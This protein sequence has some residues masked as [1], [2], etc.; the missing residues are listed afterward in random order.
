MR[1]LVVKSII[2]GEFPPYNYLY[3]YFSVLGKTYESP[4]KIKIKV[5]TVGVR[6]KK[7]IIFDLF[8]ESIN[9]QN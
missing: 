5:L 3:F 9:G 1:T 6:I 4:A 7:V 2:Y 8:Y